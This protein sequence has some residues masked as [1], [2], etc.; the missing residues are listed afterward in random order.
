MSCTP[1]K[2]EVVG[3]QEVQGTEAF[4]LRFLQ[5]RDDE[6]IRQ[7]VFREVRPQGDLVRRPR[8]ATRH[9]AALGGGA[10]YLD[11]A[12]TSPARSSGWTSSS[13]RC[14]RWRL[15]RSPRALRHLSHRF[16]VTT[17]GINEMP[18]T[19]S[20][21]E[22]ARHGGMAGRRTLAVSRN[23]WLLRRTGSWDRFIIWT[24]HLS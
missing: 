24:T 21:G 7:G 6:W 17:E 3:V 19:G 14:T 4:V 8:A 15:C 12:S 18:F 23:E 16:V 13:S 10:V 22:G 20:K 5:C 11:R 9:V 1:G 2:V